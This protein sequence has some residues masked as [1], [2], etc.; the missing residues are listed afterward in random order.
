MNMTTSPMQYLDKAMNTLHELGLV[1]SEDDGQE[2]PIIVLLNLISD[3]DEARVAAI[4]RTLDKASLFNDV[5]REQVQ[6]MEVGERYEEITD[7][8]NSIRDDAKSMVEQIEDGHL[9]TFE[10]V[11]NVWM[12]VTRGDIPSRFDKI[13]DTYLDVTAST[14]DQIQRENRILEAYQDFRGAMKESEV[15]ALEILKKAE[16]NLAAAKEA[17]SEAGENGCGL[18]R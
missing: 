9:D 14:N 18:Q 10:R 13:K 11:S 7:A 6:A 15:L 17:L 12:K 5:V 8:F 4:A 1:P 2:A 16:V 3:L